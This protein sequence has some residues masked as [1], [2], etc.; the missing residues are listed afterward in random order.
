LSPTA[1]A[2]TSSAL[3]ALTALPLAGIVTVPEALAG[4]SDP[5]VVLI[6]LLFVVGDGLVRG[7]CLRCCSL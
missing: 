4:F 5:N 7:F 2:W 1:R 6:A 3:L